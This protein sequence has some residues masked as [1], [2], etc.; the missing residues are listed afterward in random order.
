M[1]RDIGKGLENDEGKEKII[2][3]LTMNKR[4]NEWTNKKNPIHL[5]RIYEFEL[6]CSRLVRDRW[7]LDKL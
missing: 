4:M 1:Y 2:N 6:L 7:S 3:S 5:S